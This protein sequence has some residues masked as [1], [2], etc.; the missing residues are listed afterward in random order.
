KRGRAM[1]LRV[2]FAEENGGAAF[3]EPNAAPSDR[4]SRNSAI[5]GR[6]NCECTVLLLRQKAPSIPPP[7]TRRRPCHAKLQ[8]IPAAD[9]IHSPAAVFWA[10]PLLRPASLAVPPFCAAPRLT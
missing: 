8:V 1:S 2:E 9:Q 7:A 6:D 5:F 10:P 3:C 4:G